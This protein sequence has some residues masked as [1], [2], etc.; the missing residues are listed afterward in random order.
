MKKANGDDDMDKPMVSIIIPVY[1]G[2]NYLR[3]AIESALAQE[4]DNYE[5][6]VINDGSRDE[7]KTEEI[8]LTYGDRIRYYIKENGGVATALNFG[9]KKMKGEY[10][11]WLSHDDIYYPD[12]ISTQIDALLEQGNLYA[13]VYS[14]YDIWD[15]NSYTECCTSFGSYYS[16]EQLTNSVFPVLQWLT[17]S[18]TPLV[19]KVL[20]EKVGLFNEKL[21]TAQD[22]EMWFRLF[23]HGKS[24]FVPKS[25]LRS[26]IHNESGSNTMPG[27]NEELG[28]VIIE[29]ILQL[30]EG[31]INNIFGHPAILYHRVAMILKGYHIPHYYH[32]AMKG[33]FSTKLPPGLFEN[34][35]D[36]E[37]H[38]Q[39]L[40]NQKAKSICIFGT[41]Q[42]GKRLY[43]ELNSRLIYIEFFS[44]NNPQKWGETIEGKLCICPEQLKKM[45]EETLVIIAAR[46]P[47]GIKRQLIEEGFPYITT[48]QQLEC[49][50][51]RTIPLKWI[52]ALEC[53]Q[54]EVEVVEEMGLLK[55]KMEQVIFD[56]CKNYIK[57]KRDAIV[58]E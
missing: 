34:L 23:R 17:L 11:S 31:E 15:M 53:M 50:L 9:I 24:V 21:I 26:R 41:G 5:V 54:E 6:L 2:S 13:I 4:Y 37:E 16:M 35:Q 18:C 42:Y 39:N 45:K 38:I 25:L 58:Q 30:S 36:F 12:K 22:N 49:R 51:S 1:N 10:F 57:R 20:F 52:S 44:D 29:S 48:M 28:K 7:G 3:E 8:A 27:F 14:D 32:I 43:S 19:P 56:A 40:T 55:D 47:D 33:L 46:I